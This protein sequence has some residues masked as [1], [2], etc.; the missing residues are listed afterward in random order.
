VT[1]KRDTAPPGPPAFTGITNGASFTT[2]TVPAASAIGCTATDA[3]SGVVS[4]A[5]SGLSKAVGDHTL[6][7]TATDESGLTSTSALSY[8]VTKAPAAARGLKIGRQTIRSV[9]SSGFKFTLTVGADS[10]RVDAA[11]KLAGSSSNAKAKT[12]GR[13]RT[14]A[15]RGKRKLAVKISPA[16]KRSLQGLRRAKLALTVRASSPTTTPVTLKKS[17]TLRG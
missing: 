4:C 6:A 15:K 3:T 16:G 9:L 17:K 2:R 14:T 12:V 11:L 13:L 7:A 10:T 8:R 1:V 5:V